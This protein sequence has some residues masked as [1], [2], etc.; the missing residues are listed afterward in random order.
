MYITPSNNRDRCFHSAK[1]MLKAWHINVAEKI[2]IRPRKNCCLGRLEFQS[3][4][5]VSNIRNGLKIDKCR[6]E[7]G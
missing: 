7:D 1:D 2:K 6:R 4:T 5:R 3:G